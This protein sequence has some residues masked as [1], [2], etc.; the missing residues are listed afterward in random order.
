MIWRT[1]I[2]RFAWSF[3]RN[4]F[5]LIPISDLQLAQEVQKIAYDAKYNTK[6]VIK[7][8]EKVLLKV[9]NSHRMGGKLDIRWTTP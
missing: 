2:S 8:G 6:T 4:V 9:M 3:H 5:C 1:K 7:V